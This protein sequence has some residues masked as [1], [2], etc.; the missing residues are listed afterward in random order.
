ELLEAYGLEVAPF[1][2]NF[3]R[4]EAVPSW[5]PENEAE[6]YLGDW[7]DLLRNGSISDKKTGPTQELLA[8]HAVNKIVRGAS[9]P[10]AAELGELLDRLFETNNPLADPNGRPTFI[11]IAKSE[12]NRRFHKG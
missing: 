6:A 8:K 7:V 11:E 9:T 5:L 1:G 2:R 4:I 3:F 12:L 10:S